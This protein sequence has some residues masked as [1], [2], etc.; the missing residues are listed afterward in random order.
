MLSNDEL[1]VKKELGQLR[2]QNAE[3]RRQLQL[4]DDENSLAE[5]DMGA[6]KVVENMKVGC[7]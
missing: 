5:S 1:A 3:L 2:S 6:V 7:A 4:A